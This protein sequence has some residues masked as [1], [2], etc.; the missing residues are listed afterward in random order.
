MDNLPLNNNRQVGRTPSFDRLDRDNS[1]TIKLEE[2]GRNFRG[3][4]QG[5]TDALGIASKPLAEKLFKL[6]DANGDNALDKKEYGSLAKLLDAVNEM[7]AEQAKKSA[8][9]KT[10]E[11]GAAEAGA[12]EEAGAEEGKPP[13]RTLPEL[14]A[15]LK[16]L[17]EKLEAMQ[18]D[19]KGEEA[20]EAAAPEAGGAAPAA[21]EA[22]AGEEGFDMEEAIR[23]AVEM[24]LI[25]PEEGEKLM[26]ALK[27]TDEASADTDTDAADDLSS[28]VFVEQPRAA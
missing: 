22:A 6:A 14:M 17:M 21:E 7:K 18:K 15:I 11:A 16:Q 24:G 25:S 12:A 8:E 2:L 19:A 3:Q 23:M 4:L 27:E 13:E 9:G 10:E 20:G 26:Q 28:D 1:G 5:A